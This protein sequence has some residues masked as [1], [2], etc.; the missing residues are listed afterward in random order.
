MTGHVQGTDLPSQVHLVSAWRACDNWAST[1]KQS[2]PW[3]MIWKKGGANAAHAAERQT[4]ATGHL[5]G[6]D[7]LSQFRLVS[8]RRAGDNGASTSKQSLPRSM[9]CKGVGANAAHAASVFGRLH[10]HA[11]VKAT[12]AKA[13]H[14]DLLED[15]GTRMRGERAEAHAE[16]RIACLS[17]RVSNK[18]LRA[19]VSAP[20]RDNC[21]SV[22]ARE[23]LERG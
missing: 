1:C 19:C 6:T 10:V 5:Q 9:S 23:S 20:E 7:S 17:T 18:C 11:P 21:L 12:A 4:E 13:L 15:E 2:L 22:C 14:A 8:V 3:N 16:R